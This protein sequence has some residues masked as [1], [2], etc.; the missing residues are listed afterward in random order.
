M[1]GSERISNE[2]FSKWIKEV[3]GDAQKTKAVTP[4]L[5]SPEA[6]EG[7][8]PKEKDATQT[9]DRA[10]RG[11]SSRYEVLPSDEASSPAGGC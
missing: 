10:G 6:P 5:S 9:E 3:E 8:R 4:Q 2:E 7:E 11:V 1:S